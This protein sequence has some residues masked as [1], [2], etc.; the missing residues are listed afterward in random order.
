MP[1]D[2]FAYDAQNDAWIRKSDMPFRTSHFD[3][4]TFVIAGKIVV[5]GGQ[6][7]GG[8]ARLGDGDGLDIARG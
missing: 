1:D 4:A 8:L 2:A 3:G 5:I 7:D 6:L